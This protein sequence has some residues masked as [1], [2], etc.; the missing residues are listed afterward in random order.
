MAS[1]TVS[2]T[3]SLGSLKLQHWHDFFKAIHRAGYRSWRMISSQNALIFAYTL[4]LV[5]R[6]EYHVDEL[7][8]R[9]LI[10]QWY[11]MTA[12]TGRY[13]SSPGKQDGV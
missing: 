12:L 1:S 2:R 5:G 9:R 10:G 4:Y 6:T 3:R 13:T 11:F 8:L 7:E